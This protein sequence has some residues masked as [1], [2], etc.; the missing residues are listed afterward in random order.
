MAKKTKVPCRALIFGSLA[1][2][3]EPLVH[4]SWWK[5]IKKTKEFMKEAASENF[6]F[7]VINIS[8]VS[9]SH[10]IITRPFV[11]IQTDAK[12]QYW[13]QPHELADKIFSKINSKKSFQGFH[14][15]E[16]FNKLPQFQNTYYEDKY[17]TRRKIAEVY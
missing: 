9:C 4:F 6:G 2:K 13:L 8:S 5:T 14:E 3:H 10:E 12:I 16:I 7:H 11:F 15:Y 1:D 17:F